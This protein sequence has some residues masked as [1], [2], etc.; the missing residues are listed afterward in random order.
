MS[1]SRLSLL[2]RL[3]ALSC[4]LEWSSLRGADGPRLKANPTLQTD[5]IANATTYT[6]NEPLSG[7]AG[8]QHLR[9]WLKERGGKSAWVDTLPM[10]AL[11]AAWVDTTDVALADLLASQPENA[12]SRQRTAA[13]QTE[14]A[15]ALIAKAFELMASQTKQPLDESRVIELIHVHTRPHYVTESYSF[16]V[17]GVTREILER[18]H[19]YFP[20][21]VAALSAR[22]HVWLVGPA[23]GGKTTLVSAAA[24]ANGLEHRALSVCAQTTKTD[25]L[26]FIDAHG[27]YRSTAFREAFEKGMV[28]CLDEADNGNPN[29]LAVLNAA[30][31]NGEMTFPD[32]T[33]PR[34]PDFVCVACANTFGAG[35]SPL[36]VGRNQI[37]AATLDRFFFLS[38]PYDEGLEASFIGI[39]SAPSPEFDLTAGGRV[40]PADWFDV[41]SN[42]RKRA[43][44]S[45]LKVVI[46]PRATIGGAKLA[47]LGVGKEWL[48][49]GFI[50]KGLD[51]N[52]AFRLV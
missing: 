10:S 36:Y 15:S 11:N 19:A 33:V 6:R 34:H 48:L 39:D 13:P 16:K 45:G 29:V 28:F 9:G 47:L 8:R 24:R 43:E 37:D 35:A 42:A 44:V 22:Q 49:Q 40:T 31:A 7:I 17:S 32:A 12:P 1:L 21:V 20:L 3:L 25:L 4:A 18:Q 38:M 46:S 30:L 41:V 51:K 27:V 2:F 50:F 52:S 23:G 14:D 26:G 5:M